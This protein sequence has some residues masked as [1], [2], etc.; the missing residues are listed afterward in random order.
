M[1][2][3]ILITPPHLFY[4]ST[5]SIPVLVSY[6]KSKGH[7]VEQ[8]NVNDA[9]HTNFLSSEELPFIF[10]RLQ[11]RTIPMM[12]S[13]PE[14]KHSIEKKIAEFMEYYPSFK[15]FGID[16]KND[17]LK[18]LVQK[19]KILSNKIESGVFTLENEFITSG[20][21]SFTQNLLLFQLG[22]LLISLAFYP[23]YID[24]FSG[25]IYGY[26]INM[27]DDILSAVED[28]EENFLIYYYKKYVVPHIAACKPGLIGITAQHPNNLIPALTLLNILKKKLPD[29]HVTIGGTLITYLRD[30]LKAEKEMWKFFDSFVIGQGEYALDGLIKA[31][32]GRE[33]YSNIPNIVFKKDNKIISN[34]WELVELNNRKAPEF[35]RVKP[36]SIIPIQTAIGCYWAKCAFCG[37]YKKQIPE[38]AYN[39]RSIDL[40][41]DEIKDLKKK[42]APLAFFIGDAAVSPKRLSLLADKIIESDLD[43]NFIAMIRAEKEF[44]SY[45]FCAKL[46]KAGLIAIYFGL[47]SASSRMN[48]LMRKNIGE[49]ADVE[50][51]LENFHNAGIISNISFIIGFP[52]E[53]KAEA[54]ET[55]NFIIRNKKYLRGSISICTFGLCEGSPIFSNPEK[56]KIKIL[57]SKQDF[58]LNYPYEVSEGLTYRQSLQLTDYIRD[59][60]YAAE[61]ASPSDNFTLF[62]EIFRRLSF[63]K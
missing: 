57:D 53:T 23:T 31:L 52:T 61:P 3:T 11:K 17:P 8:I 41:I 21:E 45:E 34:K 12:E 14:V 47:E 43:I 5:I 32:E 58:P 2:K 35:T 54:L 13:N 38:K 7:D 22:L 33:S 63:K 9:F 37:Y 1:V 15:N 28:K 49:M 44:Q 56:Y 25:I 26:S 10:N 62:F 19:E 48:C 60:V 36:S 59:K 50:K 39:T 30:Y 51:I 46:A 40:V 24:S 20:I 29:T 6:L 4:L 27:I 42:H 16:I 55:M 18:Q